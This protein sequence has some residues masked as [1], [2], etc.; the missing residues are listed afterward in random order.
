[1]VP[2]DSGRRTTDAAIH[3]RFEIA[4]F[5]PPLAARPRVETEISPAAPGTSL[6]TE[7]ID[8]ELPILVRE[9]FTPIWSEPPQL[10]VL[11]GF[12]GWGRTIWINQCTDYLAEHR[13]DIEVLAALTRAQFIRLLEEDTEADRLIVGDSLVHAEDD[14]LWAQLAAALQRNQRIRVLMT[15]IDTP[16][17]DVLA[18]N[19]TLVLTEAELGFTK[20]EV[21]EIVALAT[22][23]PQPALA[24]LV[25]DGMHGHPSII[26][27]QLGTRL[28]LAASETWDVSESAPEM[29]VLALTGRRPNVTL[30]QPSKLLALLQIARDL[31]SFSATKLRV[32]A[33][34][35]ARFEGLDFGDAFQRLQ[36]LPLFQQLVDFEYG[37][38]LLVW[39]PAIW[40]HG[41]TDS[42]PDERRD[43]LERAL[44]TAEI[45]GRITS[46]LYYLIQLGREQQADRLLAENYQYVLQ[47]LDPCTATLVADQVLDPTLTP[48]L[49]VLQVEVRSGAD[50]SIADARRQLEGALRAMRGYACETAGEELAAACLIAYTEAFAGT[51]ESTRA[52][53]AKVR[54][55]ADGTLGSDLQP[56]SPRV[57]TQAAGHLGMLAWIAL[58]VDDAQLA[59]RF[60]GEALRYGSSADRSYGDWRDTLAS[61]EDLLG[62]R[63]VRE[64]VVPVGTEPVGYAVAL[65][66]LDEGHDELAAMPL[67]T[68]GSLR[69]T[70]VA[71]PAAEL[72]DLIVRGLLDPASVSA[73]DYARPIARAEK[74]WNS[75]QPNTLLAFA[76]LPPMLSTGNEEAA[77]ELI[78][79]LDGVEDAFAGLA[80][81]LWAQ[82]NGDLHASVTRVDPDELRAMPRFAVLARVLLGASHHRL[83][84]A[85]LA[86]F[87]LNAAWDDF[88]SPALVR[89][90][91]R[92]LPQ[93]VVE[94]LVAVEGLGDELVDAI[95]AGLADARHLVWQSSVSLTRSEVEILRL[96]AKGMKNSEIA[97]ERHVTLGTVR[98][99]LKSIY[100]KVGVSDRAGA[101]DKV[102]KQLVLTV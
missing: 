98:S 32:H 59:A 42:T 97:R 14:E 75:R 93:E 72:L 18:S 4:T 71:V 27:R 30:P 41:L 95:H 77:A 54:E 62:G 96:L 90:A 99:Q 11:A 65:R 92:Y 57:R 1:M 88:G 102:R 44:A 13:P 52:E 101:L 16:P 35:D 38:D 50:A 21:E 22:G 84:N 89:F 86:A 56:A 37:E 63:S 25:S 2:P 8:L 3:T 79:R 87:H 29:H 49:S 10:T 91:L 15:S 47:V 33:R 81:V 40:Q 12:P 9:R 73:D 94:E 51:R 80:R 70:P 46:Q 66:H 19:D 24:A 83:G 23:S 43:R 76:M 5:T 48:A 78:G 31:R 69:R 26:M 82:W 67:Q 39:A 6:P 58:L 34:D 74:I 100:R 17:Y 45:H 20:G 85:G 64:H 28:Q 7:S 60:A 61:I 68:L 36:H 55:L 53:L